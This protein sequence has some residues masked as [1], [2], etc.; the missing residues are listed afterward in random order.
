M[1]VYIEEIARS[2]HERIKEPDRDKRLAHIQ[3]STVSEHAHE[4]GHY[5]FCN[6]VKFIN[7][8]SHW[9][10]RRVKEGFHIRLHPNN[11]KRDSGIE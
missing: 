4:T 8:E 11:I 6:E 10:T 3:T 5:P 7:R 2:M 1:P 9:F